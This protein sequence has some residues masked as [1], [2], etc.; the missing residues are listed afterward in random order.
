MG[1]S[2]FANSAPNRKYPSVYLIDDSISDKVAELFTNPG[3]VKPHGRREQRI[4]RGAFKVSFEGLEKPIDPN[5]LL[6][7]LRKVYLR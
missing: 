2:D 4:I 6:N 3:V 1:G 5:A 7:N